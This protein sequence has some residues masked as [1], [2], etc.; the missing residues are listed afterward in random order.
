MFK[1]FSAEHNVK[2]IKYTIQKGRKIIKRRDAK[3]K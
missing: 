3:D 2:V 1:K